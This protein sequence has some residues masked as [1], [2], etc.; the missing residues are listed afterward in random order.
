MNRIKKQ[1]L[2][3]VSVIV[4]LGLVLTGC[5]NG[6]SEASG[7]E[8]VNIKFSWWSNPHRTEITKQAIEM[9]E[10]KYPDID[11]TMEYYSWDSYWQKL[12]T[13]AA[14]GGAPDVMQMD[15][16]R[17]MEYVNKGQLMDLAETDID[18][19]GIPDNTVELGKVDG[20]LYGLTTS[21]N[22]Q[23]LI[24]NPEIL[25]Q[26]GVSIPEENYTWEEFA[27]L[28]ATIYEETGVHGTPNEM[29]QPAFL[30]YFAR[31]KGENLYAS[32]GESLGL[33]KETLTE[34]FQYWLDIQEK[35]G[36]PSAEDN[37]AYQHNDH[38][39]SP[40]IEEKTAFNW[41]FLGTGGEFEKNLG[42]PIKRVLLPEWGNDNKPYP[43]HAAMF[44][45]MSSKT[46]H[47]EAAAKLINFLENDPEVAKIFENDRGIP[48]N[49]EN[50]ELVAENTEDDTVQR[51]NE[52]MAK[53]EE[54][55]TPNDLAPANSSSTGDILK[56]IAHEVTFKKLTPNEAADKFMQEVNQALSE[57]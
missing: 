1:Y 56:N 40:F 44:W 18:T 42:K 19:S 28:C 43:L 32:D 17:L 23:L 10:E 39:A 29:E 7:D 2:I 49:S 47:P 35:G 33:S 51:Q 45:S 46:E 6:S 31:T 20:T 8:G 27:E 26:A 36:V 38:S 5:G 11:V 15:G 53:V 37:A 9:F 24:S 34:W 16:S 57:G 13:E 4:S 25:E 55:A 54:I 21:V 48:A 41:L 12:A 52:F 3:F 22:A 50:M 30:D 14:G